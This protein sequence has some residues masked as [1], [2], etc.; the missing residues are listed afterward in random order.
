MRSVWAI[1][2]PKKSEKTFGKHPTQKPLDLLEQCIL[3]H[4]K[5]NDVIFDEA[6]YPT[7]FLELDKIYKKPFF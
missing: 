5:D 4:S 2:T 1:G 3:K 7:G 6:R